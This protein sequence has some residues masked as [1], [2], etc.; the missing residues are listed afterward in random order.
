MNEHYLLTASKVIFNLTGASLIVTL[1]VCCYYLTEGS[2]K[3][4]LSPDYNCTPVE[5]NDRN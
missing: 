2:L 3:V 5:I 4:L 1:A